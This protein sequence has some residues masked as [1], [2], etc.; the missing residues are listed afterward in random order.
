MF[1]LFNPF[2]RDTLRIAG[3]RLREIA[4]RRP[5][6]V[7]SVAQSN[8][9]FATRSWLRE[10]QGDRLE[11]RRYGLRIFDSDLTIS[12]SSRSRQRG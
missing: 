2:F 8:D 11:S 1:F 5:I 10:R 3:E 6:C 9:Y 7:A 12:T 4:Q